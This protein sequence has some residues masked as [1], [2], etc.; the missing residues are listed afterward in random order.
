MR[1]LTQAAQ[2]L[3]VGTFSVGCIIRCFSSDCKQEFFGLHYNHANHAA[4]S[5]E[6]GFEKSETRARR[7]TVRFR[8]AASCSTAETMLAS[9]TG[10]AI[11]S[12]RSPVTD[13]KKLDISPCR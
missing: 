10:E 7:R 2:A 4:P 9:A 13:E 1:L 5:T 3:M 12:G 6:N 11:A 8:P